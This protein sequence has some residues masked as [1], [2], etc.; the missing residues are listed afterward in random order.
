M[1]TISSLHMAAMMGLTICAGLSSGAGCVAAPEDDTSTV[2]DTEDE[3][4]D[5]T[6]DAVTQPLSDEWIGASS[7][8]SWKKWNIKSSW[9]SSTDVMTTAVRGYTCDWGATCSS[10][11]YMILKHDTRTKTTTISVSSGGAVSYRGG[12]A[13]SN[14][15]NT[16]GKNAIKVYFAALEA[17]R[18]SRV[19]SGRS[20]TDLGCAGAALHA[21]AELVATIGMCTAIF[22]SG[23][24]TGFLTIAGLAATCGAGVLESTSSILYAAD[25]CGGT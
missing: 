5:S 21:S 12:T 23:T 3:D 4:V 25:E 9:E 2:A 20:L 22:A 7:G 13:L 6:Q 14:T 19:G 8:S 15:L 24:I 17:H 18:L 11:I 1:K 16:H 10:G